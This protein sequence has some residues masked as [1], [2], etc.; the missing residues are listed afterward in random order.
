MFSNSKDTGWKDLDSLTPAR[1]RSSSGSG[2]GSGGGKF[3]FKTAAAS[4]RGRSQS[5]SSTSSAN[6]VSE[7]AEAV[8]PT[9]PI[10][11][12]SADA[13]SAAV[14][15][16]INGD[17]AALARLTDS[18]AAADQVPVK[19]A[20]A[21]DN[22]RWYV[23]IKQEHNVKLRTSAPAILLGAVM[24]SFL[25]RPCAMP[26]KNHLNISERHTHTCTCTRTPV[27]AP[28]HIRFPQL[29]ADIGVHALGGT[30]GTP[31]V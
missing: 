6:G 21:A 25:G 29:L 22:D 12:Y 14:E 11:D 28:A 13:L 19:T 30:L 8:A 2:S 9:V 10:E 16:A 15:A 27:P 20:P 4:A 7:P 5:S 3:K 31:L 24:K 17:S 23:L 1:G 18:A 26:F